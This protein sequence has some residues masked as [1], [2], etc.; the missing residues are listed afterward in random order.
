[1]TL[2][3]EETWKWLRQAPLPVVL[4]ICLLSST[5]LGSWVYAVEQKQNEQKTAVAVAAE[6]AAV[7]AETAKRAEDKLDK[8]NDKLDQ[9][10]EA[11][12]R[13]K[14][15]LDASKKKAK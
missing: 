7:A 12:I 5:I 9:L 13:V 4:S 8:A 10:L 1:M 6:K 3:T 14:A 2:P 15:E 11:V